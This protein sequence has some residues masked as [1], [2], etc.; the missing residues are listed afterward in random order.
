[1]RLARRAEWR[2]NTA[3]YWPYH[4][5]TQIPAALML[6]QAKAWWP[7]SYGA[8]DGK[9]VCHPAQPYLLSDD[10]IPSSR[11]INTA[12]G[13]EEL[14]H[15]ELC[16]STCIHTQLCWW[17]SEARKQNVFQTALHLEHCP[18]ESRGKTPRIQLEEERAGLFKGHH[19]DARRYSVY[20]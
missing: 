20:S 2:Q 1:M 10:S 4:P 13:R 6:Q 5:L 11:L 8:D 18:K 17:M 14:S 15:A 7:L 3:Q 12:V 9:N 16:T 19:S